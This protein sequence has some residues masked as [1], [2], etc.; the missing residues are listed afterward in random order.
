MSMSALCFLIRDARRIMLMAQL[1]CKAITITCQ[2]A[3]LQA[4]CHFLGSANTHEDD[5]AGCL[6]QM[7]AQKKTLVGSWL[8]SR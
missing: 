3:I 1:C 5:W 6:C 2:R 4:R 8:V 7:P